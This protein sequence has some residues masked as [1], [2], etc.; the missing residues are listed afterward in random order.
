MAAGQEY[1]QGETAGAQRPVRPKKRRLDELMIERGLCDDAEE[2]KRLVIAHEVKVGDEYATSAAA[3]I[4]PSADIWVKDRSRY[5]SRGGYKLEGA[6]RAFDQSVQGASCIDMG[7][8]TGGFSDCLLQAGAASVTCVDV[9]YGMLAW[10]VRSDPR[11]IVRERTNIRTATPQELGAPFD[12]LVADLSFIGLASL[13][14]SFA[15]LC[16]RG[17]VFIGLVKPQFESD[18]DETEHGLVTDPAVRERT[19]EEVRQALSDNGFDVTGV[20]ESPIRGKRAG[21]IEYL[22][23]AV[24]GQ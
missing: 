22:V 1:N 14:P 12:I 11:T 15:R 21:N 13:A 7:S 4:A 2:A 10:K 18:H 24:F 17:S 3:R 19:V 20:I 8:S 9:N 5:V 23:R 6:L 16:H